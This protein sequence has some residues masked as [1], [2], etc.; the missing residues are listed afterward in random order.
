MR[1]IMLCI[2][3]L[4]FGMIARGQT[5]YE[6]VYWFDGNYATRQASHTNDH[7]WKFEADVSA[8]DESI[9][10]LHVQVRD[11]AGLWSSP[12]TRM[13]ANL[14]NVSVRDGWYW[15]D[16]EDEVTRSTQNVG[17]LFDVDVSHLDN[18]LHTIHYMAV[19]VKGHS[20]P[21]VSR[22]FIKVPK[23]DAKV[24]YRC[25]FDSRNETMVSGQLTD[26]LLWLDVSALDDGLHTVHVQVEKGVDTAPLTFQF[27]KVPQVIGVDYLHCLC[28]LDGK[29]YRQERVSSE[30]GIVNWELDVND[31]ELGLHNIQVQVV[32]PSGA[33]TGL[34][35]SMFLR[36]TTDAEMASL[37][38]FYTIDGT[39]SYIEAGTYADGAFHFDLDVSALD[40]GLHQLA[41]M[42]VGD[43]GVSTKV[44]SAFFMKT[45]LGG[46]G[47]TQYWYWLND[48]DSNKTVVR[49]EERTSPYQLIGLLPVESV[50]IRS[51]CFHFEVD[52]EKEPMLY[53]KNEFHVR[54]F[55]ATN[56]LVDA[57]KSYLDYN[58]SEKVTGMEE[59]KKTQNFGRPAENGIKWFTLQA[60]EGDTIAFRSSQALSLQVFSPSGKEIYTASGAE[61]VKWDGCHTWEEGTHYVAVHDVTGSQPNVTLD[62]LHMDKYDVVD[63]DVR[64]VGNGGCSTITF[65]GNGFNDLYAVDLYMAN[66][67]T[68]RSVDVGHESDAETSIIFDFTD[69][70]LG[71]YDASFHFTEEDKC[72]A[73]VVTVE[74]AVD[75]ELATD[76]T[77]PSTFLRG[78]STTYTV[79]ITNKGNMT[80]YAVPIYTY[81]MNTSKNGVSYIKYEGL[82]YSE[83]MNGLFIDGLNV[84]QIEDIKNYVLS[85]GDDVYFL[86]SWVKDESTNDSVM[87]RTNYSFI[88]IA[89]NS[90]AVL[91]LVIKSDDLVDVW[92]TLPDVWNSVSGNSLPNHRLNKRSKSITED[93]YCC[94]KEHIECYIEHL[95]TFL[96]GTS[97]TLTLASLV[98]I[99]QPEVA[100]ALGYGALVS[101]LGGCLASLSNDGLKNFGATLCSSQKVKGI[102][103]FLEAMKSKTPISIGSILG[104][105]GSVLSAWGFG[106]KAIFKAEQSF[107]GDFASFWGGA[108][109]ANDLSG[110]GSSCKKRNE[111][112]PNCPPNPG[113]G[114]GASQPVNSYDPNEIY[115]YL[116]PSGSKFI[117]KD[118]VKTVNYRI[119]FENDTA[120]ATSSAHVV[121]I[122]DTL[123][124]RFFELATFAPTYICI[125]EKREQL[126][127][128]PNFVRTVDMRPQINTVVQVEG[129]Y[130]EQTGIARWLF[131]SLD[132][133]TMEPS[134]DVMQGF[135]P[136]N[137]DGTSGIGDVGYRIG[138]KKGLVD[139]TEISNRA[140]IVF[141]SNE[142]ILTPAWANIV[143]GVCPESRVTD[144][145]YKNDSIV[146]LSIEGSDERSG[147][148][149]YD[150]YVQYGV[151][152][153]WIKEAE[154]AADSTEVDFR[155]YDG[156]YYGF[157]VLATDSAGN[158][159]QKLL[160]P[161][162]LCAE[163]HLGD[164][165]SDGVVNERDAQLTMDYYLEKP[166]AILAAAADVNEDGVVNTLDV[167]LIVQMY[168][169]AEN[170]KESAPIIKQYYTIRR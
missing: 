136:V 42:L 124:A 116:S 160:Q 22:T 162:A 135:L 52:E 54:F 91:N 72:I 66:G 153:P 81:I 143:D 111:K 121:E 75:I 149:K 10:T 161:E 58:V 20:T 80:A 46:N 32:T 55:D 41:Y 119:E 18:G 100:L 53:A 107:V 123:D 35:E 26:E 110:N 126:D 95:T 82:N 71:E 114:G 108:G 5:D 27:L 105:I 131:T 122:R 159:E 165:N 97:F 87:V 67:D 148:W 104:C 169:N 88:T 38:C 25:W 48:D 166:V 45:P 31:L 43:N 3:L 125:G 118:S 90:T 49:L 145:T 57:T 156:L 139:G 21:P 36:T 86:K 59:I 39:E 168:M 112:K 142:P 96:D 150:L 37:K 93:Y 130:D 120:F 103:R 4:C 101:G 29:L 155:I 77:F 63:Q 50:P 30:G 79:K 14:R 34:Y 170:A 11:T 134:D 23:D 9:H 69:T 157:C 68:I 24:T 19:D 65:Y 158:V 127:G 78:T 92:V 109:F 85:M 13:F 47:I 141:D 163:I 2:C 99:E 51:S 98:T 16:S 62:Y 44:S 89:P 128:T 40:D 147:I 94:Y 17:G 56:R 60:C 164:V 7:S 33:A 115:G 140:S 70:E 117:A 151:G 12:V 106:A 129:E 15:F 61:S 132:P 154:L 138:V 1:K 76:V 146:T 152:A 144:V 84:N 28:Y 64:V 74:K 6:Y 8:L 133:M 113:G 137:H 83:L 102:D 73:D 167:T